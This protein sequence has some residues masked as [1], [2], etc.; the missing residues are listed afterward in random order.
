MTGYLTALTGVALI[1][2]AAYCVWSAVSSAR[3]PQGALAWTIFLVAAPWVA[4]PAYVVF[5]QHKLR[6]QRLSHRHT[7]ALTE[8]ANLPVP[9]TAPATSDRMRIFSRLAG[10]PVLRGNSAELLIDGHA[11]FD[12][13][14]RAI[15]GAHDYVLVQFYTIAD[16]GLGQ[17]FADR[18]IAAAARGVTVRLLCDRVGSHNLPRAYWRRLVDAGVHFPDPRTTLHRASRSRVNFRN[19]RKTVIVDGQWATLGGHNVTDLYLGL[20]PG[21]GHWRDTHIALKGPVV[22]QIQLGFVQDWHWQT[23][24]MLERL[25]WSPDVIAEGVDAVT[26]LMGPT[27]DFDTGALFFFSA[28]MRA[29]HRVWIATPYVVPDFDTLSALKCAALDGC[30]VRLLVP[31]RIDHYLP[32]LAAFAF[33]DELRQAGVRIYRYC[34]GFQHQKVVLID[35][36]LA[37]IG[38]ANLDNRSFRLNFETM[39]MIEDT[40]FAAR[41]DA[42]LREDMKATDLLE[43]PL[44][45][46]PLVMR[47]GAR[48]ARL[49]A[50]V[51]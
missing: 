43:T 8:N 50:P 16:D 51:L 29:R 42:M 15:D 17:D 35:D 10:L 11:T 27:D 32:W 12:A 21:M 44:S 38:T 31:A 7:L 4:V 45:H 34:D 26:V 1:A 9:G 49:L 5:G 30:D 24:E 20:D 46:Q 33:Y 40:E 48:L 41:T 3:T 28:I 25:D 19:H 6:G 47:I 2:A 13:I 23:G 14:F 18:L 36:D 37:S 39:V 22:S